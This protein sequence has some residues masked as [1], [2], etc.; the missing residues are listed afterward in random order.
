ML[1]PGAGARV[2]SLVSPYQTPVVPPEQ[3]TPTLEDQLLGQDPDMENSSL[4]ENE[5]SILQ[6]NENSS[7]QKGMFNNKDSNDEQGNTS[8]NLNKN[9]QKELLSHQNKF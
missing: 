4:Q 3:S 8:N 6:E 5:N 7:L 1:S 2:P 9:L